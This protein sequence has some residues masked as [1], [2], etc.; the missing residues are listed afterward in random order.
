MLSCSGIQLARITDAVYAID[1]PTQ[2]GANALK[3]LLTGGTG[4]V[5][6]R[7]A[8]ELAAHGHTLRF[9]VRSSEEAAR[10]S[11]AETIHMDFA[12]VPSKQT[13]L[14]LLKGIDVVINA[15]G[16]FRERESQSFDAIHTAAPQQLFEACAEAGIAYVVQLSALGADE[17]AQTAYHLSKRAADDYLRKLPVNGAIIQPSLIYAAEGSS[18]RMFRALAAMPFLFLPSG[19]QSQIQPV[20]ID[21]VVCGIAKLVEQQPSGV[22]TIAFTGAQPI[23]LRQYFSSLR[24]SMGLGRQWVIEVPRAIAVAAASM[25]GKGSLSLVDVESIRMLARGNAASNLGLSALLGRSPRDAASFIAPAEARP[26]FSD[27]L[28]TWSMP[29]MRYVLALVW[30]WTGVVSL[31]V[32]PIE[33]SYALLAQTG[34]TGKLATFM[35]YAAGL[36]DLLLGLLTLVLSKRWRPCL[37]LVQFWLISIYTLIITLRLPEFW[38]HPYGPILKNLPMLCAILVLWIYESRQER[39]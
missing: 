9:M 27:A 35:L 36:L 13:W 17:G 4:L 14:P 34:L 7:L 29:A 12:S 31:W 32:Y 28:L 8:Q 39:R 11:G 20:H 23:T 19:G 30:L 2:F 25:I 37:W 24:H 16:I 10:T 6:Q 1:F 5:G 38:I 18:A 21:D 15:V 33:E 26:V 3:I 22:H